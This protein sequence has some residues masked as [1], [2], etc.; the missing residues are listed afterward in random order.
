M[1][2]KA[3]QGVAVG[4]DEINSR[5]QFFAGETVKLRREFGAAAED[6][7]DSIMGEINFLGERFQQLGRREHALDIGMAA[8]NGQG[9]VDAMLLIEVGFLNFAAL[10]GLDDPAGIEIDAEGDAAAML[11]EVLDGKAQSA[12]AGR[13]EHEPVR[14]FGE[15]FVGERGW[16]KFS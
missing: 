5:R 2:G 12:R 6:A 15:G 3:H 8:E 7:F 11:G 13:T 16:L 4:G 10:D 1:R 14:A 9:L